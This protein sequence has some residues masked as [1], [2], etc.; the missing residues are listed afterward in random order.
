MGLRFDRILEG[1][2][3][4]FARI[5]GLLAKPPVTAALGSGK[6]YL[7]DRRINDGFLAV[8]RLLAAQ[9]PQGRWSGCGPAR[10]PGGEPRGPPAPGTSPP[11]VRP[12]PSSGSWQTRR[13]S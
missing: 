11:A 6:A 8:N 1:F 10:P 4:P 2:D 3:G 9:A 5:D 7:I 12:P 13:A